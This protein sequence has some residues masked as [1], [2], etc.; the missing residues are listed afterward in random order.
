MPAEVLG[1]NHEIEAVRYP[2]W[3]DDVESGAARGEVAD[4]A[5][6]AAAAELD[7]SGLEDAMTRRDT[8]LVHGTPKVAQKSRQTDN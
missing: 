3:T 6:D 7:G 8:V 4:S 5:I 1:D 2:D